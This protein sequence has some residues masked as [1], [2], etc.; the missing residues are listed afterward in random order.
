MQSDTKEEVIEY[1]LHLV[2]DIRRGKAITNLRVTKRLDL[3]RPVFSVY[4]DTGL[5][6]A[7]VSPKLVTTIIEF[8]EY[9]K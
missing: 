6:D 3:V 8:Q 7:V 5:P 2:E 9:Q 1:L 4:S